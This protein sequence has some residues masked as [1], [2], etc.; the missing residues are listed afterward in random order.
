MTDVF[1][2]RGEGKKVVLSRGMVALA[3]LI[4]LLGFAFTTIIIDPLHESN[5][6]PVR[7]GMSPHESRSDYAGV[8]VVVVGTK[9]L[10]MKSSVTETLLPGDVW[11]Y[12]YI[13]C[14]RIIF[15]SFPFYGKWVLQCPFFPSHTDDILRL[16]PNYH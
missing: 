12:A 1:S 7:V 10:K 3:F 6:V 11:L 16:Q 8:T 4:L 13:K 15:R 2:F 9:T 5:E 14:H